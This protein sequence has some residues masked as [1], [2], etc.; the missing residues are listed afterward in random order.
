[1][2]VLEYHEIVLGVTQSTE[3][4]CIPSQTYN[5]LLL[6]MSQ[7]IFCARQGCYQIVLE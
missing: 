1:M 5:N 3:L 2:N 4:V 7:V 6:G